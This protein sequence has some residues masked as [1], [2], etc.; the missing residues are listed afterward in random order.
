MRSSEL[1]W[2]APN[3]VRDN[4]EAALTEERPCEDR[5]RWNGVATSQG[6]PGAIRSWKRREDPFSPGAF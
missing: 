1:P 3:A 6:A 4:R 5:D 2:C